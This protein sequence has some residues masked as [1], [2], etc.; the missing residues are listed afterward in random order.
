MLSVVTGPIFLVTACLVG[1]VAAARTPPSFAQPRAAALFVSEAKTPP[2]RRANMQTRGT[3]PQVSLQGTNLK[4]VNVSLRNAVLDDQRQ[5]IP[6]TPK[7]GVRL[8]PGLYETNPRRSLI[9]ASTVVVSA[10]IPANE[11]RPGGT[12]GRTWLSITVNTATARRVELGDLFRRP[13]EALSALATAARLRLTAANDCVRRAIS[14]PN[15]GHVYASG[16]AP[17]VALYQHFGLLPNG[18]AIGFPV[19]Q[20]GPPACGSF[21]VTVPYSVMQPYLSKLGLELIRGVRRPA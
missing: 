6:T 5:F 14:D 4:A 10:L 7:S 1:V 8:I 13:S 3:Y 19:E 21:E 15:V 2:I 12:D 17:T 18:L 16:F 20:V 11:I 9:S